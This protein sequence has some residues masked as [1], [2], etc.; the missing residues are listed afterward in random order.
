MN[1]F[2]GFV[3][4][5]WIMTPAIIYTNTWYTGY[6]PLC[7][8]DVYDRYGQE[9]DT[10]AVLTGQIFGKNIDRDQSWNLLIFGQ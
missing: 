9:Y 5:F 10:S 6:L 1:V 8:A 4:F 3:V 2:G 7:T